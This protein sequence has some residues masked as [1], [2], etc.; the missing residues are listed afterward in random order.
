[1][2]GRPF[3]APAP[4]PGVILDP[5]GAETKAGQKLAAERYIAEVKAVREG[6]DRVKELEAKG[7]SAAADA[8]IA[9]LAR[10]YGHN[11][12]V[13][14]L[15]QQDSIAG[16]VA[17]AQAFAKLQ[18]DRMFAVQ[19][20]L[21]EAS[22]PAV[23]DIEFPADWAEKSRRRLQ[24]V[25]LTAKEKKIIEALDKP[26]TV[27]F[28]ERPFE[29][30]LQ[31]LSNMLDLPLLLDK[32]S[33]E[34]L[35][36]DLKRGATLEAR[37]LSARTVLRSV[38]ASQGLTFV[39]K[40]E[41]IQVVTVERARSQ[42]TTRV[43]YLG[44]LV[45]GGGPFGDIRWGPFLNMQQTAENV[46]VLIATIEKSID[47]LSW[48]AADGAGHRHL[49]LPEHVDHRPGVVRSPLHPRPHVQR[50]VRTRSAIRMKC[51]LPGV[52]G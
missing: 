34:D 14:I 22:L 21:M 16:R 2:E 10:T 20:G 42:L 6:I 31:D 49:P 48:R 33:V 8:E 23:R 46:Q 4:N 9:K 38:L 44:D 37:G 7:Q 47:P 18:N 27:N 15:T 40:D 5:K 11:P 29:E 43:Y 36:L 51:R 24:T 30:A 41:T 35:G 28:R 50:E 13:S 32:K 52:A 17:D 3:A 39:V 12:A 19:K 25:Q 1:M 45:Q 26:I